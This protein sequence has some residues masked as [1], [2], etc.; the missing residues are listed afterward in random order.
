MGSAFAQP[1]LQILGWLPQW[2]SNF[3][4]RYCVLAFSKSVVTLI[5]STEARAVIRD[6]V[7]ENVTSST[8]DSIFRHSLDLFQANDI[9]KTLK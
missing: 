5:Y 6:N 2:Q 4:R 1:E 3:H 7:T 9:L 8:Y